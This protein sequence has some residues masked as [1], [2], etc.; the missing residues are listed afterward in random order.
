MQTWALI[1]DSYRLLLSRKLFWITLVISSIVVLMYASIGFDESGWYILFGLTHFDSE[2]FKAGSE[3]ASALYLGFFSTI[4]VGFW[5]TWIATI[6]ALVS[7]APIFNDFM[8][9]GAIDLVL[10]KPMGRLRIFLVKYLGGLMFVLLQMTLFT[11]GVFL[12]VGWRVG[13]WKPEILLAIPLVLVFFSY[14]YAVSVLLTMLTRSTVASLMLTLIFWFLIFGVNWA[15]RQVNEI[16]IQTE[17]M[18]EVIDRYPDA[19][20]MPGQ[21]P[22]RK[23]TTPEKTQ[24]P[25]EIKAEKEQ[26]AAVAE[27]R[28]VDAEQRKKGLLEDAAVYKTWVDRIRIILAVLPKTK[29][30][31]DL[32]EHA[33][34]ESGQGLLSIMVGAAQRES[35]GDRPRNPQANTNEILKRIDEDYR[36][37][38]PYYIIG[39]SLA[40]EFVVLGC[41]CFLFIRRDF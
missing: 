13:E 5:F 18:A 35:R 27:Q 9:D 16:R 7:T 25:A 38:S 33:T 32:V 14:L 21:V 36:D 11:V 30:T 29:Q 19:A 41:A 2:T 8:A 28:R 26:K 37:Q 15:E 20:M 10:S 1:V 23:T 40:F 34:V 12:C 6:L 24:T 22:P 17:Y 3:W 31:T 4:I 39:T